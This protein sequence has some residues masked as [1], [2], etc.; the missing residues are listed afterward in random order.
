MKPTKLASWEVLRNAAL[1][2][3]SSDEAMLERHELFLADVAL[4]LTGA[5]NPPSVAR[6]VAWCQEI[7]RA[8]SLKILK[9][10]CLKDPCPRE[11]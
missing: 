5:I 1:S 10:T 2:E 4:S 7:D 9:I 6:Y 3:K 8:R 11:Q